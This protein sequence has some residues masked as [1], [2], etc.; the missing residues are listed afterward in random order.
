MQ[1]GLWVVRDLFEQV[2]A[3]GQGGGAGLVE[4]FSTVVQPEAKP[5]SGD[6]GQTQRIVV[7]VVAPDL[8]NR[9][10]SCAGLERGSSRG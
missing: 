3:F 1:R 9:Q 2:Q 8:S 5:R 7:A 6:G 10:I 4:E